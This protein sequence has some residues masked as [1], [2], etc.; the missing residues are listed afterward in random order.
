VGNE[1]GQLLNMRSWFVVQFIL[2]GS[3]R[4]LFSCLFGAGAMLLVSRL[5]KLNQGLRPADIY[6]RRLIWLLVFGLINGYVLNW[7]GD[8]LYHYAIVGFF[9][10]PFR[11]AKPRL[12]LGLVAFFVCIS[13]LHSFI[14]K[15]SAF[16]TRSKGMA[17]MQIEAQK[18]TLTEAQK[19][20]LEKWKAYQDDHDP[21]KNREKAVKETE[22]FRPAFGAPTQNGQP[23]SNP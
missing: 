4:G 15:R 7:A 3:M 14:Q 5:E 21:A 1:V 20:D 9:L 12:V 8:I 19:A 2:E 18:Q 13:M 22:Q 16:E 6:V 17:A 11:V 23:C 10:F